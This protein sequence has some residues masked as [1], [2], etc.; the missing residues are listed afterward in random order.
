MNMN[1][2]RLYAQLTVAGVIL[3]ALS[4]FVHI[5]TPIHVGQVSL[6]DIT[7]V[8][9]P[10]SARAL[11]GDM[12][13]FPHTYEIRSEDAFQLYVQMFM[14]EHDFVPA[15]TIS[16][17]IIKEN[18]EHAR[19]I[20]I[21]RLPAHEATWENVRS[22]A[23]G[24]TLKRGP[25]F[26]AQVDAG[27]YRIEV[28]TPQNTERYVLHIG[29]ADPLPLSYLEYIRR[30][31]EIKTF[32]GKSPYA[33]VE[34]PFVYIPMGIGIWLLSLLFIWYRRMCTS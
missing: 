34:S 15:N 24:D 10:E 7:T 26:N 25:F 32:V 3:I 16:G 31:A 14:P 2:K 20:E 5:R 8:T 19:V 17:I 12:T 9:E 30:I 21:A 33:I 6:L 11:Y 1:R 29:T 27:V 18:E 28:S 23:S 13:G 22:I 4:F